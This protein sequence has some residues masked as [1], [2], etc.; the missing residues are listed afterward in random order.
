MLSHGSVIENAAEQSRQVD[1]P[2]TAPKHS[3]ALSSQ[4]RKTLGIMKNFLFHQRS[5]ATTES[6][7]R[8]IKKTLI[9]IVG[10]TVIAYLGLFVYAITNQRIEALLICADLGGFKIPFSR[11]MCRGYLFT[12]RGSQ[13][14]IDSLH[15][16]VGASFAVQGE[17]SAAEREQVLKFLI[18]KGLDVNR[19]DM[20]QLSP[21]HGAVVGNAADEVEILLR[22]G[23][24]PH[25]KDKKFGLTPLELALKLDR[26]SKLPEDRRTV[27]SL[28]KNAR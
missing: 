4:L 5:I 12:F 13:D 8:M 24:S 22:N 16:H 26:E 17:S 28:L 7:A 27:I 21:L 18:R 14:D 2:R 20:H 25:L 6:G 19:I 3:A 10:L 9:G 15:Q 1:R 11:E 23:A